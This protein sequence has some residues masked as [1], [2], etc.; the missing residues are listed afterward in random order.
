MKVTETSVGLIHGKVG[1]LIYYVMN[2]KQYVRRAAIPGK[3]RKAEKEGV[4]PEHRKLMNRFRGVQGY[5]AFFRKCVS[6]EIWRAAGEA[7]G[8]RANNLFNKTN[9]RCF[10]EEG[11]L[12]DFATF[13]FSRGALLLPRHITLEEEGAGRYRVR[14]EEERAGALVAPTDRLCV[15]VIYEEH[16]DSPRLLAEVSGVRQELA[17]RFALEK[18]PAETVHVYCFWGREDG[19]AFSDSFYFKV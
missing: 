19:T 2:G 7:E 1:N 15:G 9:S 10:N 3:K 8:L 4:H 12:A 13:R 16:P 5:Y 11:N 6:E 17:G 18:E 14:W